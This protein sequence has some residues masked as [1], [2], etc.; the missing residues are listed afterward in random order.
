MKDPGRPP[1]LLAGLSLAEVADVMRCARSTIYK[2]LDRGD[3][4]LFAWANERETRIRLER[5][6]LDATLRLAELEGRR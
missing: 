2:R 5:A 6:L 1:Y 3:P 4:A